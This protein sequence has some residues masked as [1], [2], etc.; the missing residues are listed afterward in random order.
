MNLLRKTGSNK[1]LFEYFFM[2]YHQSLYSE[3][4]VIPQI[5]DWNLKSLT[6]GFFHSPKGLKLSND[7]S[8]SS[9]GYQYKG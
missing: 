7:G 9:L 8:L 4:T 5:F 1:E 2:T 3:S 6:S